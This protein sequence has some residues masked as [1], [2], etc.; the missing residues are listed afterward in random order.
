MHRSGQIAEAQRRRIGIGNAQHHAADGLR[1]RRAIGEARIV[2]THEMV[3]AVIDAVV[4][5]GAFPFP[6]KAEVERWHPGM[7][8]ERR[9][10]G[11]R[12]E[13]PH[14]QVA[15]GFG[16]LEF[17]GID[18]AA[19][20]SIGAQLGA[21]AVE[22]RDAGL[23]VLHIGSNLIDEV[24][25]L[26]AAL[27][28]Q[29]AA[30]IAI[31]IDIDDRLGLELRFMGFNPFGAAQQHRFLGIPTGIDDGPRRP[32]AGLGE[33]PQRFGFR[34]HGDFARQR[35]GGAEHPAVM[36][37]AAHHPFIGAILALQHGDDIVDGLQ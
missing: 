30:A 25:V 3:I 16:G 31:G 26:V 23:R 19:I 33:L 18:P 21:G 32:P 2:E 35:I 34:Q 11:A 20:E 7:L 14:R 22:H 15:A 27:G 37:I 10:V 1:Q 13:R 36:V 28:T 9:I 17:I 12:A 24:A 29:E 8:Q 4:G 5:A 6:A